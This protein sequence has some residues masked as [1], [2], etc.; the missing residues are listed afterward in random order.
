MIFRCN[1]LSTT[2]LTGLNEY[3]FLSYFTYNQVFHLLCCYLRW[4]IRLTNGQVLTQSFKAKEPLAAVRLYIEM[5]RSDGTGPFSLL[6]SFPRKVFSSEDMEKPLDTLG[7]FHIYI[8]YLCI[9]LMQQSNFRC[10]R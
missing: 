2:S 3:V 9:S 5:N 10:V 4:Q 6:T 7:V 1:L 8:L